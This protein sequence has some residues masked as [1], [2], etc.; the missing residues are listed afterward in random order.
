[1][2]F[3]HKQTCASNADLKLGVCSTKF[4]NWQAGKLHSV[5]TLCWS[6][7]NI[8]YLKRHNLELNRKVVSYIVH[9]GSIFLFRTNEISAILLYVKTALFKQTSIQSIMIWRI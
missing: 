5:S 2:Y 9:P 4:S 1:M 7:D 8:M 3:L 6:H